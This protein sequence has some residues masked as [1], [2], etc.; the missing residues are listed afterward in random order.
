MAWAIH[1]ADL[2]GL[3][4]TARLDFAVMFEEEKKH[5]PVFF[6]NRM[7]L[8]IW[9]IEQ[10]LQFQPIPHFDCD[11]AYRLTGQPGISTPALSGYDKVWVR[12]ACNQYRTAL[13]QQALSTFHLSHKQMRGIHA[14]HIVNRARLRTHH[15][16]GWVCLFPVP[17]KA[18]T[19]FGSVVERLLPP[20]PSEVDR[21]DLTPLIAFKLFCGIFPKSPSQLEA[22]MASIRRQ[23]HVPFPHV[24]AFI[25]QMHTDAIPYMK[26]R[27]ATVRRK[28]K[29][30]VG[31][32]DIR[33]G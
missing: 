10:G 29:G 14:D 9:A 2:V 17:A 24:Q 11:G 22:A 13:Q 19:H 30:Y 18:N 15:L 31:F 28:P 1:D 5:A 27:K 20:V 33:S 32:A 4:S 21:I 3:M 25:E 6:R 8:K 23:W 7:L 12:A 16:S 26:W